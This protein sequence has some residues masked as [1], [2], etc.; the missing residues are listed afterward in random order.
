[1]LGSEREVI[2]YGESQQQ[3]VYWKV[4][5]QE[6]PVANGHSAQAIHSYNILVILMNSDNNAGQSCPIWLGG[7]QF[8]SVCARDGRP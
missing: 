7:C 5:S 2:H 3:L 1:M 6:F 8:G 4:L